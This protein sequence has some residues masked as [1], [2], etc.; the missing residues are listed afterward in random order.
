MEHPE[1]ASDALF[2]LADPDAAMAGRYNR[3]LRSLKAKDYATCQADATAGWPVADAAMKEKCANMGH[4]CAVFAE[5]LDTA[6]AWF[7]KAEAPDTLHTAAAYMHVR[8]ACKAERWEELLTV[9]GACSFTEQRAREV[10]L[11]EDAARAEG[12]CPAP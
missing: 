11:M 10:K 6:R 4:Y 8:M 5:D 7:E 12:D 3:A 9:A 1:G 2:E